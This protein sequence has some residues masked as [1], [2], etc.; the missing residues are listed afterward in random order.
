MNNF[1]LAVAAVLMGVFLTFGA[2]VAHA[3]DAPYP[4]TTPKP[5]PSVAPADLADTAPDATGV[6]PHTG[7]SSIYLLLIGGVLLVV[8][9]GVTYAS[10]KRNPI[11]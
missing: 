11:H 1:R 9:G 7:G 5:T 10:R 2:G 3:A 4:V 6:L 8:G